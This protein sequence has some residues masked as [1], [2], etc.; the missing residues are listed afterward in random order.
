MESNPVLPQK[1]K[2][3]PP[4]FQKPTNRE[5]QEF[6]THGEFHLNKNR[7]RLHWSKT[8]ETKNSTWILTSVLLSISLQVLVSGKQTLVAVTFLSVLVVLFRLVTSSLVVVVVGESAGNR[9][10]VVG[11]VRSVRVQPVDKLDAHT[12]PQSVVKLAVVNIAV[13]VSSTL[14]QKRNPLQKLLSGG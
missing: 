8:L 3:S 1:T 6:P 7:H 13:C 10:Q 14:N 5:V 4:I 11:V 9:S 2:H 12:V